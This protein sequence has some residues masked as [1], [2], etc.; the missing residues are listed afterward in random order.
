MRWSS[1]LEVLSY[2]AGGVEERALMN[3]FLAS[4]R[5]NSL[6]AR[7]HQLLL[8]LWA[9]DGGKAITDGMHSS[10]LLKGIPLMGGT[11]MIDEGE[12]NIRTEEVNRMLTYYII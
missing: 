2:N 8:A 7:S 10:P 9:S 1:R 11:F 12:R 3:H 6:F 5:N 4:G